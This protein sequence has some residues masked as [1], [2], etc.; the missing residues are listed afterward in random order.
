SAFFTAGEEAG[1]YLLAFGIHRALIDLFERGHLRSGEAAI[2]ITLLAEEHAGIKA[3]FARIIEHA[4]FYAVLCV[5][6]FSNGFA[7]SRN[8]FY[9]DIAFRGRLSSLHVP[10]EGSKHPGP[11]V[12]G[13][14][15]DDAVIV[16]GKALRL[17]E[18]L[19]SAVGAAGK[20]RFLC[21]LAIEGLNDGF[22]PDGH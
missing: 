14:P 13:G 1:K 12:C 3:A 8:F 9:A 5:T 11:V 20:I 19:A 10:D 4:V 2:G 17:H 16:R 7:D 6:G 18:G 21:R 15:G 22:G